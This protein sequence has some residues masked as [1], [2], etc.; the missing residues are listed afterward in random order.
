MSSFNV[1]LVDAFTIGVLIG[2]TMEFEAR[3]FIRVLAGGA[4][5]VAALFVILLA[6]CI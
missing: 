1:L 5:A 2:M 3:L 4:V 6:W